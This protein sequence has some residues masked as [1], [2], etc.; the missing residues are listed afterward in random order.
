MKIT[1]WKESTIYEIYPR[2]FKDTN[3]DGIG[4]LP[5]ILSKADYLKDLGI[6][7][8][9][10]TPIYASPDIDHGYDISDYYAIQ[11][12]YGTMEEFELLL[13]EMHQRD[14]RVLMDL[15][16]NH[17]SDKHPWFTQSRSSKDNP[18]R[19]YYIW[20]PAQPDGSPPNN[21]TSYLGEPAWTWDEQTGEYYLHL[22]NAKQPDL[23]WDHPA[24]RKDMYK[25]MRFWLDKGIDGYR[26]DAVNSISKDQSFPD[27]NQE[28]LQ[29]S[30]E[31]FTKNGPH[32]H[33][34]LQEM[35]HEVFSHYN[36]FT[37]GETSKVVDQDVLLYTHPDR[38]E[39]NMVLS[40]EASTLANRTEDEFQTQEWT[41]DDLRDVLMKW[42]RD[43]GEDGGWFGLYFSNHDQRRI[44]NIFADPVNYRIQS[45]K[46][47]STMLLTLLG[48]PFIYQ[49]EELG[50]VHN[51]LLRNIEDF[52]EQQT[53][54]YYNLMVRERGEDEEKIMKRIRQKS[55]DHVR[56]PMQWDDSHAA[57]FTTGKP[58]LPVHPNYKEVNAAAQQQDPH[59]VLN[60]YKKLIAMRRENKSLVYGDFKIVLEDHPQIIGYV[61]WLDDE[62][63]LILLNFSG[64]EAP[65]ELPNNEVDR[66][67][68]ASFIIGN[69]TDSQDSLLHLH[70]P[71]GTLRPYE[72]VVYKSEGL[73]D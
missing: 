46:M 44:V 39:L 7:T 63:W 40:P 58:W 22:Y 50:M 42:Q 21:W 16:L 52:K 14:I 37:A 23:N 60:Y 15:V 12:E 48:T 49:G 70:I 19:D 41:L 6:D 47:L 64:E 25:M 9:W 67:R 45:A 66:M 57:G 43:I 30:G 4:D 32:I 5:G 29:A 62:A 13:K 35:H 3:G 72:A 68:Q 33:E 36:V 10:L 1:Q 59:S 28:K 55:R 24:L 27:T 2:S 20:R 71:S 51:P 8:I 34:Y 11:P 54:S 18:Y 38:K 31:P 61:R 65:Y 69:Y 56:T 53:L 26:I 17:T 73:M